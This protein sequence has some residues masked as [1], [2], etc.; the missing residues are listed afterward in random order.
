[1]LYRSAELQRSRDQQKEYRADFQFF[2]MQD[3][4]SHAR[5]EAERRNRETAYLT[6]T[7][8]MTDA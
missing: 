4:R 2:K 5:N 6:P 3:A 8:E 1:M 7:I